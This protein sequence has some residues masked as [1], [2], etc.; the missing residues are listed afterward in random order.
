[1]STTKFSV[2]VVSAL[3]AALIVGLCASTASATIIKYNRDYTTYSSYPDNPAQ[4][5]EAMEAYTA[6]FTN[7]R[8]GDTDIPSNSALDLA[9]GLT[10]TIVGGTAHSNSGPITNLT[11][12]VIAAN[13][14]APTESFFF[15]N[16]SSTT[17]KILF[18]LGSIQPIGEINT[19][20]WHVYRNDGRR[21]MQKY[22][23]YASDGNTPGFKPDDNT[24][25][26]WV[27]LAN[28]NCYTGYQSLWRDGQYG[29][30]ILPD[31]GYSMGNYRY[32][33]FHIFTP[34]APA[35]SSDGTF[36]QEIDIVKAIPEPS[37]LVL[38]VAALIGLL[39]Y[40]W[41]RRK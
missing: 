25:P 33:I 3:F 34:G 16:A 36:Y 21:A 6:V 24:S 29:V 5:D 32:F 13:Q 14:D 35:G 10:P 41:R 8:A 22:D 37:T 28:V 31:T 11:N 17:G 38:L 19:Y 4:P 26:G 30:S 20:S 7:L 27:L 9:N 39:C 1:M 18:D 23:L 40:A 2:I 15:S 12:G